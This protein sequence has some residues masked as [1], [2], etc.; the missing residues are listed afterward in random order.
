MPIYRN[1]RPGRERRSVRIHGIT[2]AVLAA[3]TVQGCS[4]Q[5]MGNFVQPQVAEDAAPVVDGDG[6]VTPAPITP[7]RPITIGGTTS[8]ARARMQAQ[9][10]APIDLQG[11]PI[12]MQNA[13]RSG[14]AP[15]FVSSQAVSIAQ[16]A[17]QDWLGQFGTTRLNLNAGSFHGGSLDML[18]P[19]YDNKSSSLLFSQLGIRRDDRFT[20]SYRTTI[21]AGLGYRHFFEKVMVGGNAFYDADV[22]RGNRRYGLGAELWADYVRFNANGYFRASGWKES[23]D[24]DNTLEGPANGF[25]LRAESYLPQLPQLGAKLIYEKYYGHDVGLFGSHDRQQDPS[26]WTVGLTYTPAPALTFGI[27]QRMGQDGRSETA[28]NVGIRYAIGV[29]LNKQFAFD[30]HAVAASRKLVNM[31]QDLV[32]RNNDIVLEYRQDRVIGIQLPATA[33]GVEGTQITFPVML[34]ANKGSPAVAWSGTA[35]SFTLPYGGSGSA[36]LALPA[37]VPG[38]NNTYQLVATAVERDY[39]VQSNAMT[40]TVDA[41]PV[42]VMHVSLERSKAVASADGSDA[43]TFTAT[44]Q[45]AKAQPVPNAQVAW[46]VTKGVATFKTLARKTNGIGQAAAVLTS[47]KADDV[48]VEVSLDDGSVAQSDARFSV[49]TATA[50]VVELQGAPAGNQAAN[51]SD[52]VTL[53]ATVKDHNGNLVGAGVV[54]N[55]STDGGTLSGSTSTTATTSIAE[56]TLRA[57]ASPALVHVAAVASGADMGKSAAINYIVDLASARA[58]IL[59]TSVN[60]DL[61]TDSAKYWD[62]VVRAKDASGHVDAP[63][64]TV[65]YAAT[66]DGAFVTPDTVTAAGDAQAL[67]TVMMP[68]GDLG[69]HQSRSVT[70]TVKGS[71]SDPGDQ[72]TL[73]AAGAC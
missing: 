52:I 6:H 25:D 18:F 29:P 13:G 31:R 7:Q 56:V 72:T 49:D 38:G 71:S 61:T 22:T 59:S 62:I 68:T 45:D 30:G 57:P 27:D 1:Q 8:E 66:S 47:L 70:V 40:I 19:L 15:S 11:R 24:L 64:A 16:K 5:G 65:S 36:V 23:P 69:C 54:V 44:V 58:K 51:G 12:D 14:E 10:D 17:S 48:A 39:R 26:A 67:A 60:W 46:K 50:A 32:E 73:T 2:L 21:N 35:A 20:D 33:L 53:K 42:T 3:V 41:A 34:S 63:G 43:V 9:Q 4:A 37:Y 28:V 55:W